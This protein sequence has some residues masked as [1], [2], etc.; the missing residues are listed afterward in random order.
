LNGLNA[1]I[2]SVFTA[3]TLDVKGANGYDAI[4]YDVYTTVFAE[5]LEKAN[6]YHV[7]I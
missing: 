3:T 1:E 2:I 5:P 6:V 4:T 7:T